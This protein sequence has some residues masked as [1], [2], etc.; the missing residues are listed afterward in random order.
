I[1]ERVVSYV[2]S[3]AELSV[4]ARVTSTAF[5]RIEV[6]A[7]IPDS[8]PGTRGEA[9]EIERVIPAHVIRLGP[10][11]TETAVRMALRSDKAVHVASHG[12]HNSQNPLF[13]SMTVGRGVGTA[14]A[15]DGKLEVH[16]ILALTTRSPLVFLSGCETGLVSGA[17]GQ[18]IQGSDESSLAQ[19]FLI[20]GAQNVVAT[21][22]RVDDASAVRVAGSFYRHLR[23]GLS[24]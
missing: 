5:D 8:L 15:S 6:F 12:M 11:S 4:E 17:E 18:I 2:P 22:W 7:P 23:N 14:P 24:T 19:A 16:E 3:V 10:A 20:A 21:L 1:E 13:S 9:E